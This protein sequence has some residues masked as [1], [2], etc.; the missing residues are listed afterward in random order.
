M[1]LIGKLHIDGQFEGQIQSLDTITIGRR[2]EVRGVIKAHQISVSGLLDAEIHCDELTVE[3]DGRVRGVVHSRHMT[4]HKKGCFI[5][6]RALTADSSLMS[7]SRHDQLHAE[8]PVPV[9]PSQQF[10]P[11]VI[12]LPTP[13]ESELHAAPAAAGAETPSEVQSEPLTQM[14]EQMLGEVPQVG[15]PRK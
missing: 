15:K 1:S 9:A 11:Q 7:P 4:I 8:Q 13:Q 10:D 14:L 2:G 3:R 12:E 6:E 5:G